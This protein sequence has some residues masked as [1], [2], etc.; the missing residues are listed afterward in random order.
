MSEKLAQSIFSTKTSLEVKI[1][2]KDIIGQN[3]WEAFQISRLF[4]IF[5]DCL[6]EGSILSILALTSHSHFYYL[7]HFIV[8][9]FVMSHSYSTSSSSV[10]KYIVIKHTKTLSH[11]YQMLPK[12]YSLP[13]FVVVPM[14]IHRM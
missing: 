12:W 7:Q 13:R 6:D 11:T 10:I 5:G 8:Y 14:L 1:I 3:H 4:S 2:E 9:H